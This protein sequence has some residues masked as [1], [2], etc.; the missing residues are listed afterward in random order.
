VKRYGFV[1]AGALL[2]AL[3]LGA[4]ARAPR[5]SSSRTA[6]HATVPVDSLKITF[7]DGTAR[8]EAASV[9]AGHRLALTFVN[10][11]PRP[12][13]AGLAGYED[14]VP[15]APLAPGAARTVTFVA[16]RPGEAFAFLVDG[17][18]CG[19]LAVTGS[20]LPEGHR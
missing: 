9:P 6:V 18:P 12:I 17:E 14:R 11:G 15:P 3:V 8:P 4:L 19:R 2:A 1:L 20:H 7:A 5:T 16:D 13:T 10:Q